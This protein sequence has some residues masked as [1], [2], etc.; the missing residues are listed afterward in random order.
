VGLT[1]LQSSRVLGANE[2][3]RLGVIGVGNRGCQVMDAFLKHPDVEIAA[4]CDVCRTTLE[5]S[6]ATWAE[7]KAAQYGDF[8]KLIDPPG[9]DA[10]V[11]ATPDHWHAIQMIA[12]C[13]A[14]KEVYCEKPM[15]MTLHEGRRMVEAARERITNNAQANNLLHYE[16]RKP[17]TLE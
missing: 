2:R 16:Y 10:V 3:V 8:R 9:L 6:N 4:M 7:G 17:W 12:A 5:A 1:A 11:V 15:S 13:N 14:G